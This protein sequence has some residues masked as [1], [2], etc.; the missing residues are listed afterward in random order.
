MIFLGGFPIRA[1]AQK[2]RWGPDAWFGVALFAAALGALVFLWPQGAA[3]LTERWPLALFFFGYGL[4]TIMVGFPHPSFGHV[5]FDRVAQVASILVLGP[6]AAAWLN[7]AAS[8]IYPLERL[9]RGVPLADVIRASL[10]NAG[11]M[12]LMILGGGWI[13][14]ALGGQVPL[15]GLADSALALVALILTMQAINQLGMA[16]YVFLHGGRPAE[17]LNWFTISIELWSGVIAVL[18]A[19]VLNELELATTILL[20]VVLSVGMLVL[21]QF[22]L[23]R[24]HL[25]SLVKERTK[26]LQAKSLE[27]EQQANQDKLTG[28]YNRRYADNLLE[29]QLRNPA[30]APRRFAIALADIDHFKQVN[31]RFSHAQGDR[32]LQRVASLLRENCRTVDM[33]ARYGGEEFL[34]YFPGDDAHGSFDRCERLRQAVEG[35]DWSFLGPSVFVTLSF[36]I[37]HN[38]EGKTPEALLAE[39]DNRLYAAKYAGRNRVVA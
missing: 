33:V 2:R 25:E 3:V 34:L 16:A 39:A 21:K 13:Y 23:M 19:L 11:L 12:T 17:Q 31:D 9:R 22:A 35:A 27:L 38:G 5:S 20:L 14:Q 18:L 32:V 26:E 10:T 7:G 29:A 24:Q 6:V 4:F 37:A 30:Q 15:G 36:G 1:P 8:L 28:L